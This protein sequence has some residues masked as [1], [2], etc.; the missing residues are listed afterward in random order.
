M[1]TFLAVL[2]IIG[3]V[4]L[5]ILAIVLVVL[6]LILF[7][8]VRYYIDARVDETDLENESDKLKERIFAKAG[9]GWFCNLIRG[10]ISYPDN[11]TYTVKVLF[12]MVFPGKEKTKEDENDENEE[13]PTEMEE[14]FDE[15][16][17]ASAEE[18]ST[19][20]SGE[21]TGEESGNETDSDVDIDSEDFS[22]E[23]K[24]FLDFLKS[25]QEIVVKIVKTPQN[26]F[27]KIKCTISS[28]Y[29]KIDMIKKTLENDIFKRAFEI[30]KKKLIK[31]LKMIMPKKLR[32][33]FLIGMSDPTQT[34]DILAAY[35]IL[36]PVLVNKVYITPDFER[37]VLKGELHVKGKIRLF[38]LL[39][40]AA[41]LYFN[42]D[43]KKTIKRFKKI[44]KS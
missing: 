11:T 16:S 44:V 39:W 3:I 33:D 24:S 36:Y 2:K 6:L 19:E 35:G 30:T 9:F 31:V 1:A 41:V 17:E 40:A 10:Y 29:D 25:I 4:L 38:G 32:A 5:V 15:E 28:I 21:K 8:P 43:V 26:V 37:S 13:L 22:E 18:S 14:G 23:K 42:K 20:E 12:F 34:A 7:W 27:D